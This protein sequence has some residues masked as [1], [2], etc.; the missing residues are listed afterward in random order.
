MYV[1]FLEEI[2]STPWK[3]DGVYDLPDG[4]AQAF[5]SGKQARASSE[6]QAAVA[7]LQ[8]SNETFQRTLLDSIQKASRPTVTQGPPTGGGNVDYASPGDPSNMTSEV[9]QTRNWKFADGR[10]W[11]EHVSSPADRNLKG[12][13]TRGSFGEMCKCIFYQGARDTPL[14][15]RNWATTR[16]QKH[17][18]ADMCRYK[19]NENT[20]EIEE[21]IE[22]TLEYGG[23]EFIKRT[24]TE[25]LSGGA[26]YGFAVKPE[27]YGSLFEIPIE[28]Q[29]FV[30]GAF[31]VP[32][33][34]SLEF[35]WPALD[36]Y[37][38]PSSAAGV[39]QSAIY[40]G[41]QL[42][43]KGEITQRTYSDAALDMITFK[44]VDLTGFTTLS[45]DL[46]ADNYIA[47][48]AM[49]Q[50]VFARGFQWMEDY[51]SIQGPGVGK[52]QGFFNASALIIGGPGSTGT[53]QGVGSVRY[54]T[55]QIMY[56]DV[57]WMVSRLHSASWNRARW[58]VNTTT[59]PALMALQHGLGT[60][61]YQPNALI[62]QSMQPSII[63]QSSVDNAALVT[64][65][66]GSLLGF[67]LYV[68]EK[69]PALGT[70]GDINLVDPTQYGYAKRQGLEVGLSEHFLFDTDQIAY[71]FKLRHDAK[72][73]WRAA[74]Q[75]ADGSSTLVSPFIQLHV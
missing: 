48:D 35:K 16:L 27:W 2:P 26:T 62:S 15:L 32:V 43:Y 12:Q 73:L 51:M 59:I 52:P 19:V 69:V 46:I 58:I 4:V 49:A 28:Q 60:Y 21:T 72:S 44:I 40:A 1:Q 5:V 10:E 39:T 64:R 9:D 45:R 38:A 75:Q 71:R 3:K 33:G 14:E 17:Y 68:S 18:G 47:M 42:F 6:V 7:S 56:D 41:F 66:A 20:G 23:T 24:G 25:S 37:K 29:A 55:G 54:S 63:G 70:L 57:A 65:P 22:R 61:V 30:S 34:N 50:R 74:Y 36:Q 11:V 13:K 31:Q 67:P 8:A 53:A